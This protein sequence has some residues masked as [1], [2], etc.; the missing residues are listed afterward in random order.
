MSSFF[1]VGERMSKISL[2]KV[3]CPDHEFDLTKDVVKFYINT[4]C[5][6]CC[7]HF[8]EVQDV[9]QKKKKAIDKAK[10]VHPMKNNSNTRY[11]VTYIKQIRNIYEPYTNRTSY[12]SHIRNFKKMSRFRIRIYSLVYGR[13]LSIYD[14]YMGN[15]SVYGVVYES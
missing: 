1:T 5:I 11:T 4:R 15:W 7:K 12:T 3:G 6:F 10:K 9:K 14:L 8:M 13:L 2:P